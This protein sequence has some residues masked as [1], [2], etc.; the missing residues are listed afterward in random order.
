[1][2]FSG[3]I[4]SV[5]DLAMLLK[6]STPSEDFFEED[7]KEFVRA[8]LDM[9]YEYMEQFCPKQKLNYDYAEFIISQYRR[10]VENYS[11]YEE[12]CMENI[13][14]F[15]ADAL[16]ITISRLRKLGRLEEAMIISDDLERAS[17]EFIEKTRRPDKF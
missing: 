8:I 12:H 13:D 3:N 1:M 16:N 9:I 7:G 6:I 4:Q 11:W 10:F 17:E 2:E 5:F 14:S 15:K